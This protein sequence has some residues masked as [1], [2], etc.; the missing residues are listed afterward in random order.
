MKK[1]HEDLL[2]NSQLYRE[3]HN[4]K[5]IPFFHWYVFLVVAS[6]F[7]IAIVGNIGQYSK[8]NLAATGA[9]LFAGQS[10]YVLVKFKP[11]I[12]FEKRNIVVARHSL[13]EELDL[14]QIGVKLFKVPPGRKAKEVAD[15]ISSIDRDSIEYAEPDELDYPEVLPND[16]LFSGSQTDKVMMNMPNAWDITTGSSNVVVAVLDSGVNCNHVDLSG[17][18]VPGRNV[19]SNNTDTSDIHGHGTAVAGVVSAMGNNSIGVAGGT[20][21]SKIMPVRITDDA[22]TGASSASREANGI[23]WAAD[24]GAKVITMSFAGKFQV[25]LDAA[26]YAVRKGAVM[27]NSAGNTGALSTMNFDWADS[28]IVGAA[29]SPNTIASYSTYGNDVD[30]A[31]PGCTN[32][33]TAVGGGYR[34][35]CGTSNA[36]PEIA[37]VVALI[38]SAN[39]SL[40][41]I[42]VRDVL[43]TTAIDSGTTGRDP[44]FGWGFVD[45]GAAVIKAKNMPSSPTPSIPSAPTI[46]ASTSNTCGGYTNISWNSVSGATGYKLYRDGALVNSN[47]TSPYTDGALNSGTSYSYTVRATNSAGDSLNSNTASA[48]ASAV[49]PTTTPS[50]T[51][52]I[53]NYTAVVASGTVTITWE[54]NIPSTGSVLYGAKSNLL[55]STITDS[56]LGTKHS[57]T[58]SGLTRNKN[59]WYKIVANSTDPALTASTGTSQF[60][61]R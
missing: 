58:I 61:F 34:S 29:S 27:I 43:Y 25:V 45:A 13:K 19:S 32:A 42:Q 51:L 20:W 12:S 3:W 56:T 47:A 4:H 17:L 24:N 37:G 52:S 33:T 36:T 55:S 1:I 23:I 9:S 39:P 38:R 26:S 28:I 15:E 31:G 48:T 2:G 44:F 22:A 53:L 46:S 40:T 41:P 59:Y 16:P 21:I 57:V 8:E 30:I 49:C 60:R 35:F 10:E 5:A 6:L 11:N 54:T 18:C 7:T 14:S 50:P